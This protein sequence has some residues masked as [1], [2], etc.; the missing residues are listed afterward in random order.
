MT[1]FEL[2]ENI[3]ENNKGNQEIFEAA[4]V[5]DAKLKKY[6]NTHNDQLLELQHM[7]ATSGDLQPWQWR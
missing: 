4:K 3:I 1:D 2:L 5:L 7:E 6:D